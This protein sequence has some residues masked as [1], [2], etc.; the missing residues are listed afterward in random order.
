MK[1]SLSLDDVDGLHCAAEAGS[2]RSAPVEDDDDDDVDANDDAS[3][4]RNGFVLQ[5]VAVSFVRLSPQTWD[6]FFHSRYRP[7]RG[8]A[9]H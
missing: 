6:P 4:M 5:R 3:F 7:L 2:V 8:S 9:A 1:R